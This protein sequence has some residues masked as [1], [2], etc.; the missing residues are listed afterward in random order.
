MY[1]IVEV[2]KNE[3]IIL[4]SCNDLEFAKSYLK[5]IIETNKFLAKYYNWTRIP[6]FK[7]VEVK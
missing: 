3:D 4:V 1:N 6:E 2:G 7:I 5:D